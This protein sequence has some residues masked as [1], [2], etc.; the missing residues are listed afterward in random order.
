[1]VQA[2]KHDPATGM[3]PFTTGE[4]DSPQIGTGSALLRLRTAPSHPRVAVPAYQGL[5]IAHPC[6]AHVQSWA[7]KRISI[8]M[9]SRHLFASTVEGKPFLVYFVHQH[10]SKTQLL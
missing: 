6:V 10:R 1:M 7:S 5:G 8:G 9:I 3:P 2:H 4:A